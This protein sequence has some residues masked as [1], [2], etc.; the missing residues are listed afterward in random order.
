MTNTRVLSRR[1][2]NRATLDRQF[3]LRRTDADAA[4][5]VE[6]LVGLQTQIPGNHFTALWSRIADFSAE[7]FSRRFE[8]REFVRISLQRSTIHTV[9]ARDCVALRPLLQS[10]QDRSLKG[11]FGKRLEGVDLAAL[12]TRARDLLDEGPKTFGELGTALLADWPDREPQA[13][14]NAAR[15][16]LALVQVPPRGLWQ[17]GGQAR[18][19]TAEH[20]L[21]GEPADPLSPDDLILRYLAAFG[22]ASVQDA[23]TWSGLTRLRECF[24]RL[25]EQLAVFQDENGVELF[26]LPDAPRPGEDVAAPA[27]FFPDYDNVFIGHK[28]RARVYHPEVDFKRDIWL[29]NGLQ[30]QFSVDGMMSGVWRLETDKKR[31]RATLAI[32]PLT[33]LPK[34]QRAEIETEAGK[35]LAF[36]A[37]EATAD[38]QWTP[39]ED[40]AL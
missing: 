40:K 29:G 11:A 10:V 17:Q 14:G 27:R 2:L 12:A 5:V 3:L 35:L 26:D 21:G 25:R 23:Q 39:R 30:P 33:A 20:W 36:L 32:T 34:T 6:H 24:D 38:V 15:N 13:L 18:H 4:E 1:E 9:T 31:T 8:N 37:P 22:P 16:G 19:T 28:D 7:D